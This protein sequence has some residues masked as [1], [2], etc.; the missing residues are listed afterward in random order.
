M[1]KLSLIEKK[2][3]KLASRGFII[4][5]SCFFSYNQV[6]WDAIWYFNKYKILLKTKWLVCTTNAHS[7]K[8]PNP[9]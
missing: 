7:C 2:D 4:F 6:D 8:E 3:I 1:T 5:S 9:Y